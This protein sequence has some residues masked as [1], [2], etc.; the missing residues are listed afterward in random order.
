MLQIFPNF[1]DSSSCSVR[2]L[3]AAAPPPS[4][5]KGQVKRAHLIKVLAFTGSPGMSK[6]RVSFSRC[7]LRGFLTACSRT[8]FVVLKA[9][10]LT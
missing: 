2:L 1:V 5:S 4:K 3:V 10:L 6:R 8:S 7:F 9:S